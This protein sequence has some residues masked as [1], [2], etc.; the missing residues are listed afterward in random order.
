MCYKSDDES[1]NYLKKQVNIVT[2]L[3]VGTRKVSA[4]SMFFNIV[5]LYSFISANSSKVCGI[6]FSLGTVM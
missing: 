6:C 4:K 3:N 5:T 1:I 2:I